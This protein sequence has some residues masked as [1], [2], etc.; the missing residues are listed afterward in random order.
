MLIFLGLLE[1]KPIS[2]NQNIETVLA[3][4]LG[5]VQIQDGA[6]VTLYRGQQ[7]DNTTCETILSSIQ[8]SYPNVDFEII[9]GGD[10]N[11]HLFIGIE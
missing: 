2:T 11:Y 9:A 6:L 8:N 3:E 7:M 4:L 1:D 10:P 5:A